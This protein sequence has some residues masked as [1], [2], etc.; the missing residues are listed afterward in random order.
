[1]L[2]K[3]IFGLGSNVGDRKNFLDQAIKNLITELNLINV[4]ESSILENKAL[5][6][7]DS[8]ANWDMDFFN[9]AMSA[10]INLEDFS[11]LKI[12][13][14]IKN[15]EIKLGRID[16]GRWSP[17][18]IDI[19]ILA[20][21]DLFIDLGPQLQIPHSQLF[22]RDFFSKT[23]AEIEPEFWQSCKENFSDK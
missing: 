20:I 11:I 1:M 2:N 5:L 15:I 18:E 10:E 6:L 13:D 17:R 23:F 9:M 7:P 22:E 21:E 12:L 8:P 14:I 19:D 3:I 4:K 16:R